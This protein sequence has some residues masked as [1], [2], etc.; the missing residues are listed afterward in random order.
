MGQHDGSM[1]WHDGSMG[2]HGGSVGHTKNC[3]ASKVYDDRL[4]RLNRHV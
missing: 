4:G 2:Q 3:G 1:G